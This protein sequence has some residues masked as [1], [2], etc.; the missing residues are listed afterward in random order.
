MIPPGA[1]KLWPKNYKQAVELQHELSRSIILDTPL[2]EPRLIAGADISYSK[3]SDKHYAGVIVFGYP[4]LEIIERQAAVLT[5][6]FP[7]IP[8]LLSFREGPTLLEAIAKLQH[9]PDVYI[10][11]GQGIAHPRRL[12]LAS[13]LGILLDTPS[14]GCA[15]KK[16]CGEYTPPPDEAG[17]YSKLT[18]TGE[19]IGA[20]LRTRNKVKPVFISPGHRIGLADS[21]KLIKNC[22]RGYRLPEPTR[23]AHLYVNQ[24]RRQPVV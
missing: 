1:P 23:L 20:V 16:L 8:G 22:C 19:L 24:L 6:S 4:K 7:Y 5:V 13:H 12:G 3:S 2:A 11:D 10:F 17:E 21:I 15:K 14:I 18:H 9:K